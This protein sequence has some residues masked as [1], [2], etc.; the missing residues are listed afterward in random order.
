MEGANMPFAVVLVILDAVFVIHAAKTGRFWP[1]A[2]VIIMLPGFGVL[3]YIL[4]E[5]LPEWMG[6]VP[7]RRAKQRFV[8]TINPEKRYRAL[9]EELD[10]ADTIATRAALA[11]ECVELGKFEEAIGHYEHILL[12]PLGDDPIYMVRKAQAELGMGR[13]QEAVATLDELRRRFPDYQSADGHLLYARALETSGRIT[14]ALDEYHAL[15][16]YYPGAEPR[17]RYG[18][19]LKAAGRE[20]EARVVLEDVLK[21]FG[22]APRHARRMQ[23]EWLSI[24]QRELRG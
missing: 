8:K 7:A 19:L 15:S 5:L 11:D 13:S 4:V 21:R 22:R 24:A 14:E 10:I 12:Q 9:T 6:S 18:Q 1:W 16:E 3:G 17:V 23:A 2:Y 20:R